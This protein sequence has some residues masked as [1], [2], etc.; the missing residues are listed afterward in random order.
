MMA[1]VHQRVLAY[2]REHRVMTLATQGRDGPWAAAVFYASDGFD[3]YFLSSPSTRH[4]ADLSANPRVAATIQQDYADWAQIRGVQL[5]GVVRPLAGA[6]A[7]RA[8]E[9]YGAKFPI[10][11]QLAQ[12]PAAIVEAFAKIGWYRVVPDRLYFVDN[13]VRFGHRDQVIPAPPG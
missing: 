4:C 2:L 3:L 10:V 12:A 13:S 8:R 9:L 7:A 1:E 6:D 11:G 5:E